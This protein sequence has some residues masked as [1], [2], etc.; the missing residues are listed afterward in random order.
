MP[1]ANPTI[2]LHISISIPAGQPYYTCT[3]TYICTGWPTLSYL[4]LYLYPYPPANPTIPVPISIS[5]PV[6]QPYYT[7]T[8]TCTYISTRQPTFWCLNPTIPIPISRPIGQQSGVMK[9]VAV[10]CQPSVLCGCGQHCSKYMTALLS[11]RRS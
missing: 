5:T 11:K 7:C 10:L 1:P 6:G 4:Y 9:H 3:Y 2:P 8:C